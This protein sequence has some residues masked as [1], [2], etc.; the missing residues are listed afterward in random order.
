MKKTKFLTIWII[1]MLIFSVGITLDSLTYFPTIFLTKNI[2]QFIGVIANFVEIG[3]L[4]QL[5]QWKKRGVTLLICSAV[6]GIL[7]TGIDQPNV[8]TS[9]NQAIVNISA[10][11]VF[12]LIVLGILYLA[13]RPVWKKFK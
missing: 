13:I 9:V 5:L 10:V 4:V 1:L 8:V 2:V 3:A 12:E 7:V 11:L 6:V